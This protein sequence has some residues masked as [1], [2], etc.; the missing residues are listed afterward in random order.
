MLDNLDLILT[1]FTNTIKNVKDKKQLEKV[2]VDYIGKNG[3]IT[4]EVKKIRLTQ[5]KCRKSIG[6]K[7]NQLKDFIYKQI[8][9]TKLKLEDEILNK[10]LKTESID[11]T[12]NGRSFQKGKIHPISYTIDRIKDIFNSIGFKYL[13]GPEI[14]ND[15][16]NFT[17]L[18][19]AQHHPARQMHD[20]FYISNTFNNKEIYLLRTH[21]ST[22]QI[23]GMLDNHPPLKI[24]S[25]GKV[26][27]SDHD[28]THSPMFH[29]FECLV[30]DKNS[31]LVD[32]KLLLDFFLKNF[33]KTDNIKI[34]YRTSYFPF[35]EPSFEV[36][37]KY[38]PTIGKCQKNNNWLEILGCGIINTK[39]LENVS[40][41]HSQYQGFA[42]GIGIERLAMIKYNIPDLR[43]FFESDLRWLK[44]YG[45]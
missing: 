10:E 42:I 31:S 32:L 8:Q 13:N 34:R 21:T 38:E 40:I 7:I 15:W 6:S 16:N 24:F 26:Y 41:D 11:V 25:V 37:I 14:E 18:N 2:K 22:V 27:R 45:F 20:T 30:V 36:D 44:Y 17:A 19:I 4:N 9:V 1:T 35:T 12:L 43:S 3:L 23:R 33:F 29:Q 28:A 39:V 5:D